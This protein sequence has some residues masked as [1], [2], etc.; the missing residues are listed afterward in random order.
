LPGV[1]AVT[2]D[3]DLYPRVPYNQYTVRPDGRVNSAAFGGRND[4]E[5]SVDRAKLRDNNP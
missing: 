3:E 1:G 2:N 4:L 5:P